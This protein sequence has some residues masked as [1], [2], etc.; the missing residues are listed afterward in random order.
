MKES[1]PPKKEK[2]LRILVCILA[3]AAVLTAFTYML[4]EIV[5]DSNATKRLLI[6]AFLETNRDAIAT[7]A[8][9]NE[10]Q[11]PTPAVTEEPAYRELAAADLSVKTP[12]IENATSYAIDTDTLLTYQFSK[13]LFDT[14]PMIL[15]YHSDPTASYA[16]QGQICVPSDCLFQSSSDN[17]ITVGNAITDVL[18]SA[19]IASIHLTEPISDVT[20]IL[21]SYRNTYPSIRYCLDIRRDGIYTTDGR[22]VKSAGMID[23]SPAA[24]LML[25]VGTDMENKSLNWQKNLAA[26]YRLSDMMTKAAPSLIR[27][28]LLRPET[29]GQQS[30]I[31]HLT[32]FVGTTGNTLTEAAT[33]ARFFAR[34]LALFILSNC[35]VDG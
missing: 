6:E 34:Y 2:L 26:A 4:F 7:T 22:I 19:G 20:K 24:Q 8:T 9:A 28:I 31:P 25:C 30:E 21:E 35:G 14:K 23:K 10:T 17:L 16:P 27:P 18:S 15:I 29:L 32:L 3:I 5:T 11:K 13:H 1:T 12:T 33:S